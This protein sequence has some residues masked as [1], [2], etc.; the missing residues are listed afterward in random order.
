M[1]PFVL[2]LDGVKH[3][4]DW[5]FSEK[6]TLTCVFPWG[7]KL[8]SEWSVQALQILV[9][10]KPEI[11]K[12][13]PV[14]KYST[15]LTHLHRSFVGVISDACTIWEHRISELCYTHCLLG[16]IETKSCCNLPEV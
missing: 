7:F 12:C 2:K 9:T 6:D 8:C 16:E 4:V 3:K 13:V 1:L 14:C 11:S 10:R 15:L 5:F